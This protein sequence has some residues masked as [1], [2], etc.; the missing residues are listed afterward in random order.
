MIDPVGGIM[1]FGLKT[2]PMNSTWADMLAVW[3]E[4]DGI[5]LYESAWNFDH[6]E[7]IFSDRTGPCLEGWTMLAAM[8]QATT[9]I[10]LGCQV[11]GM[12]YRHPSVLANMAATID[13]ISGGRLIVG[14]GAGWN[15]DECTALGITLP[16]LTDRFDQFDEGCEVIIRL[17][18]DDV[19]NFEGAWFSLRE[20]HCEPKPIQRPHPPI[21]IGGTGPKRTLRAVARYAQ[22]WNAITRTVDSWKQSKEILLGHCADIGRDPSEIECSVNLHYHA[23]KG[24]GGV[25]EQ[26]ETW[27]E[28]G[29]DVGIVYL[30]TPHSPEP[31]AAIAEAL[32]GLRS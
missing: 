30:S 20:A 4:A 15:Q 5:D 32:S 8:A 6:F 19:A 26:A 14:L 27:S 10:R 2:A 24:I 13:V 11:T 9:R 21:A 3:R 1:R 25:V 12:P 31:L 22:H 28:A 18:R 29:A 7:P 17:L 23:D 16:P